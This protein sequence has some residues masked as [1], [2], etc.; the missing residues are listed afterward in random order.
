MALHDPYHGARANKLLFN[1]RNGSITADS[2][3]RSISPNASGKTALLMERTLRPVNLTSQNSASMF[4]PRHD[5][6]LIQGRV[7]RT[8]GWLRS[9]PA[10][11]FQP[12][13]SNCTCDVEEQDNLKCIQSPAP[14]PSSGAWKPGWP[15]VMAE[16]YASRSERSP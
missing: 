10:H 3:E 2:S 7:T 1:I 5:S 15:A 11:Q 6:F 9:H 13:S 12:S 4:P 8:Q 14:M 16:G